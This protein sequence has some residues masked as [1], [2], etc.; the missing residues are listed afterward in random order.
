MEA[1]YRIPR[2]I[3]GVLVVILLLGSQLSRRLLG[4]PPPLAQ[5][6]TIPA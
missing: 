3:V 5:P 4:S 2:R 1:T 6:S